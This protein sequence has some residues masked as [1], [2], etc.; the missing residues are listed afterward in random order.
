MAVYKI[1]VNTSKAYLH[2]ISGLTKLTNK[3]SDMVSEILEYMKINKLTVLNDNV[4]LHVMKIAN[5]TH[6]QCYYNLISN[7]KKKKLLL[8]SRKHMS[9][10]NIL[11]PGTVLEISYIENIIP[12]I[13]ETY[14]S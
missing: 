7:L 1:T 3:E 8:G 10:K 5:Y 12:S 6:P 4:K 9:F 2:T 13:L 14:N 11:T